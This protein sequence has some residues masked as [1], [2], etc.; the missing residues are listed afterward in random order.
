M[1]ELMVRGKQFKFRLFCSLELMDDLFNCNI[2]IDLKVD[3]DYKNGG[4]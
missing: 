4:P 3:G 2:E 1:I